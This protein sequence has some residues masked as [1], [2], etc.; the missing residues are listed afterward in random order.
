MVHGLVKRLPHIG[1]A[2]VLPHDHPIPDEHV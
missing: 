2:I 1:D